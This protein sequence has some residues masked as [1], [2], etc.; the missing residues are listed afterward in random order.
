MVLYFLTQPRRT[1]RP[2]RAGPGIYT[3]EPAKNKPHR[4]R[5]KSAKIEPTSFLQTIRDIPKTQFPWKSRAPVPRVSISV[6]AAPQEQY[7]SRQ[8]VDERLLRPGTTGRPHLFGGAQ[9]LAQ[10]ETED[11]RT[12]A[13]I[14]CAQASAGMESPRTP[15]PRAN[16]VASVSKVQI[17]ELRR[18]QMRSPKV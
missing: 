1:N 3:F 5:R 11:A 12:I 18:V 8:N 9:Q 14:F 17:R 7:M 2:S 15:D 6:A 16:F 10:P 13:C 4:A